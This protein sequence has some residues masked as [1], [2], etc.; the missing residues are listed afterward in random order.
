[1]EPSAVPVAEFLATV[2]ERRRSE[3]EQLISVL[4]SITGET[5]RMWGPSIIGFGEVAYRYETGR[6][7]LMPA[8]GFSPRKAAIT[9]YVPEGFDTY[10]DLLD[11]LGK[12]RITVSC[13]YL[14]RL[15]HAD[16]H[17]LRELLE[18]SYRHQLAQH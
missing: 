16:P 1:M 3:A 14:T 15:E 18:R 7:G 4:A 10:T 8:A 6:Q 17:V 11:R 12:H 5:P 13:L 2:S 9:I